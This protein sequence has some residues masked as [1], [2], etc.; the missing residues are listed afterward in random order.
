[1][2][3][4]LMSLARSGGKFLKLFGDRKMMKILPYDAEVEYLESTGTQW[5]DTGVVV[6]AN[7][8][9]ELKT[10]IGKLSSEVNYICGA[11]SGFNN[12]FNFCI[13]GNDG[14]NLSGF[15]GV[16]SVDFSTVTAQTGQTYHLVASK[17]GVFINGEKTPTPVG[18]SFLDA[19]T[20]IFGKRNS[21]SVVNGYKYNGKVYYFKIYDSDTIVRDFIP[22]LDRDMRPA[23]YD[24]VTGKLFYNKGTGEF[25]IGPDKTI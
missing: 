5:I 17:N 22:V 10:T 18:D 16:K 8:R 1:M 23:M 19:T 7:S 3:A 9:I 14:N 11:S 24:R 25:L 20:L 6:G 2:S 15:F 12:H 21:I 13:R 4:N